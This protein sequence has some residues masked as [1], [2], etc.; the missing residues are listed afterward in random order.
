MKQVKSVVNCL[1][2][3]GIR[4][5]AN[6]RGKCSI[7]AVQGFRNV[8]QDSNSIEWAGINKLKTKFSN[9]NLVILLG[10]QNVSLLFLLR[11]QKTHILTLFTQ[12]AKYLHFDSTKQGTRN[13]WCF[14]DVW[15]CSFSSSSLFLNINCSI[16]NRYIQICY[17]QT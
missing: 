7:N 6:K 8:T 15:I 4:I 11:Y 12:C 17:E 10:S 1:D 5:N 2:K 16:F 13:R 14:L 3:S 9:F